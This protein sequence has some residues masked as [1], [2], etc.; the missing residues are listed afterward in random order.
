MESMTKTHDGPGGSPVTRADT[1]PP[2]ATAPEQLVGT[3]GTY[4]LGDVIGRGGMGDVVAAED[5]NLGRR[6]A[7]KRMRGS[8]PVGRARFLREVRIQAL[9]DHPAIV[10]VHELGVDAE[11][12]PFFTMKRLSGTTLMDVLRAGSTT[13]QRL[14]R[15]LVDVCLAMD[16]AHER[17]VIHRDLKPAN[18]M[19]GDYGEVYVLDWGVARIVGEVDDVAA[20][21][22]ASATSDVVTQQGAILG[23]PGYMSPEQMRGREVTSATDVYALGSMLFE[24][25]AD[26]PL[27]PRGDAVASTLADN[28]IR[29][30]I[31]RAPERSIAPELDDACVRA[32]AS[33]PEDRLSAR[34]L[35]DRIQRFLDGDRDVERRRSL[36]AEHVAAARAALDTGNADDRTRAMRSAGR[37][38]ALDPESR[39]A[40]AL[41][42][43]F[44]LEPPATTPPALA[45]RLHELDA[46]E[47]M[48][49]G[50][51]AAF[52][53]AGYL[54][55]VPVIAMIGVNDWAFVGGAIALVLMMIG[56]CV[57]MWL[58]RTA[59]IAWTILGSIAVLA[60][61]SQMFSPIVVVPALAVGST[62][63]LTASP[64]V[65][66]ATAIV[67]MVIAVVL[68]LVLEQLDVIPRTVAFLPDGVALTPAL[69]DL[70][71]T[72]APII[73]T[74]AHCV[75]ILIVGVLV[76]SVAQGRRQSQR[77]LESQAWVLEQLLP[78]ETPRPPRA[79]TPSA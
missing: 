13:Q 56:L 71:A 45:T 69:L 11:G 65:R 75:A 7:I 2:G 79:M 70:G 73:I 20:D 22:P 60:C 5:S 8:S 28:V 57:Y 59:V 1:E 3:P 37:A 68:P 78:V 61:V 53:L 76:R 10:P 34:E 18:I 63:A 9:L 17:K 51:N 12:C 41:V 38:I 4:K 44:M 24:I 55:F 77:Q 29:S 35:A 66:P 32:L 30:P 40:A 16:F 26:V 52:A 43:Q 47:M 6:V 46:E 74:I 58:R 67:G 33:A 36:A 42:A 49:Q 19:L 31:E 54:L 50:R 27:Y 39:E 23:T 15:A 21:A 25:L 14:L 72:S 64:L 48:R 62:A